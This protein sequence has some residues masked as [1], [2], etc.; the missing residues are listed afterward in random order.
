MENLQATTQG[1]G[2]FIQHRLFLHV[3]RHQRDFAWSDDEVEQFL[4]DIIAAQQSSAP[5][6]FLG[7]VVVVDVED[8]QGW[9]ILD[10]QQRLATT[11][12]VYAAIRDW[13]HS[14]GFHEDAIQLQNSHIGHRQLGE[15]DGKPRLTLNVTNQTAFRECVIKGKN[16]QQLKEE[17]KSA[18]RYS[19]HR[20]LIGAVLTCRAKLSR[21]ATSAGD[22]P[23]EQA[24][25]LYDLANYIQSRAKIVALDVP[26]SDAAYVIF[27]SLND[28][29]LDL[30]V[31]DL[32]KNHLFG[33]SDAATAEVVNANWIRMCERIGK[34]PSDAFLKAFWT[35][36]YGRIQR[37]KLYN[38]WRAR[39]DDLTPE[40]AALLS[41]DLCDVAERFSA[42]DEPDHEVWEPYSVAC[43]RAVKALSIL[44]SRQT[45]P[46]ILAALETFDPKKP[47]RMELLLKHLVVLIVRHQVVGKRRGGPLENHITRVAPEIHRGALNTPNKVWKAF[48]QIAPSDEEFLVDLSRWREKNPRRARY[49]LSELEKAANIKKGG[50]ESEQTPAWEGLTLEHVFPLHPGD[51]WPTNVRTDPELIQDYVHRMGNLCLLKRQDN[52]TASSKSFSYKKE[53]IYAK[54]DLM[55]TSSIAQTYGTW[56]RRSIMRR[57]GELGE[58]ALIAWPLPT[59]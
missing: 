33:R 25:A 40:Q 4:D 31:L 16:D 11:T 47:K 44:G 49:L 50:A 30:S 26:S 13:L 15:E 51:Q 21:L 22:E 35:S 54:S 9:E 29:G 42:L 37:G 46:V 52:R 39:Y 18:Q 23:S 10:G 55:L 5:D 12:M 48:S 38:Q 45:W 59:T 6:Y 36:R 19:S 32:V 41:A 2:E 3:P 27:E 57:Q 7:L 58:L 8:R 20:L 1:I 53:K 14:A 24:Q 56:D 43:K 34:R 28:R 17:Y